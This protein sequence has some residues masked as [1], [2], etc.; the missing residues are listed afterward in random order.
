MSKKGGW[1]SGNGS[2]PTVE[3]LLPTMTKYAPADK[4]P[5]S[6]SSSE[7]EPR[8]SQLT[9]REASTKEKSPTRRAGR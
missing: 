8:H 3:R 4:H 7:D 5:Q 6:H 1:S 9:C 2:L